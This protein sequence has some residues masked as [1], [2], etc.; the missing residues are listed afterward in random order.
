M[1]FRSYIYIYNFRSFIYI[2]ISIL[3]ILLSLKADLTGNTLIM[4]KG[5]SRCTCPSWAAVYTQAMVYKNLCV[6]QEEFA[7]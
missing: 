7:S 3:A 2:Y 5:Q 4:F 6:D 1:Y